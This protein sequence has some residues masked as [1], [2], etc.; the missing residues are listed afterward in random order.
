MEQDVLEEACNKTGV[1]AELVSRLL[2][3]EHQHGPITRRS[4][5]LPKLDAILNEEWR[6]SMDDVVDELEQRRLDD[7]RYGGRTR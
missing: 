6:D 3:A 7:K 1:P 5:I 4:R 2:N